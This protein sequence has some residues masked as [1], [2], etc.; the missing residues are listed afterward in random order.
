MESNLLP[1]LTEKKKIV[2]AK[3]KLTWIKISQFQDDNTT[4][5]CKHFGP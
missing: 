2:A 5:I 1:Q 3:Y 4:W